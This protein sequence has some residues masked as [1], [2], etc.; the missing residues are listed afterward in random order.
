[1]SLLKL[2]LV[3]CPVNQGLSGLEHSYNFGSPGAKRTFSELYE[4][5]EVYRQFLMLV[6]A[7][8]TVGQLKA[9]VVAQYERLYQSDPLE[10]RRVTQVRDDSQYDLDDEFVMGHVFETNAVVYALSELSDRSRGP[11]SVEASGANE[12]TKQQVIGPKVLAPKTRTKKP[13]NAKETLTAAKAADTSSQLEQVKNLTAADVLDMVKLAFEASDHESV[14]NET[15]AAKAIAEPEP[16]SAVD[17]VSKSDASSRV[18]EIGEATRAAGIDGIDA[19][20]TPPTTPCIM[21]TKSESKDSEPELDAKASKPLPPLLPL[22]PFKVKHVEPVAAASKPKSKPRL[23]KHSGKEKMLSTS[24]DSE[25]DLASNEIGYAFA[26]KDSAVATND[27]VIV[28]AP[29]RP[30]NPVLFEASSTS[31]EGSSASEQEHDTLAPAIMAAR[32]VSSGSDSDASSGSEFESDLPVK[33]AASPI[34]EP[35]DLPSLQELRESIKRTPTPIQVATA[36]AALAQIDRKPVKISR[37]GQAAANN[38]GQRAFKPR[39]RKPTVP[40][41]T[42]KPLTDPQ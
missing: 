34:P 24:S 19:T 17:P 31:S 26:F 18:D 32:T 12:H 29:M 25:D 6:P 3:V 13:K 30:G 42:K 38:G 10:L 1:M 23:V 4:R 28:S 37:P 36:A 8:T 40:I 33:K 11:L 27:S 21:E 20:A 15:S 5:P 39:A 2:R 9:F 41:V 14:P 22:E 7:G 35:G 16:T